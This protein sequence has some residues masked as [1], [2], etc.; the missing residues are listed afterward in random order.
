MTPEK[1]AEGRDI[2]SRDAAESTAQLKSPSRSMKISKSNATVPPPMPTSAPKLNDIS[3]VPAMPMPETGR[4]KSDNDVDYKSLLTKV[5]QEH[6]PERLPEVDAALQKYQV[7]ERLS[8]WMVG[9]QIALL[10]LRLISLFLSY[11]L[12]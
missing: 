3:P 6:C 9:G 2:L 12:G 5:F 10:R 8:P 7:S 1:L 4:S 11:L